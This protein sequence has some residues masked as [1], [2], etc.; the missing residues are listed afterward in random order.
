MLI[1]IASLCG[2]TGKTTVGTNLCELLGASGELEDGV[3]FIRSNSVIKDSGSYLK[4]ARFEYLCGGMGRHWQKTIDDKTQEKHFVIVETDG[5]NQWEKEVLLESDMV[6]L[7]MT[8]TV[9]HLQG[10]ME[11]IRFLFRHSY[12]K[13]RIKVVCNRYKLK[14]GLESDEILAVLPIPLSKWQWLPEEP[15]LLE[16]EKKESSW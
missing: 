15:D 5:R 12:P 14:K 16:A 8:A 10:S 2:G 9:E 1:S 13:D 7:V 11:L 4:S 6:L 3:V